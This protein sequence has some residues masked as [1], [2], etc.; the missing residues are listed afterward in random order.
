MTGPVSG[1]GNRNY[2]H[3]VFIP[4]MKQ[5]IL[6]IDDNAILQPYCKMVLLYPV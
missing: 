6:I 2:I 5:T 1:K 4:N 3:S